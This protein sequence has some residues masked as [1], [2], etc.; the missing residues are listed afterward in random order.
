[1]QGVDIK[2]GV[3]EHI[4]FQRNDSL[5]IKSLGVPVRGTEAMADRSVTGRGSNRFG[6]R[7]T[8]QTLTPHKL[9]FVHGKF[10]R[11]LDSL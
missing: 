8:K 3:L 5:F 2:P 6:G 4:K 9:R 1:M 7:A 10:G 11:S